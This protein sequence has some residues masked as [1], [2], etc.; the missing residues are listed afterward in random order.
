[1][2]NKNDK[3]IYWVL[4]I[5][6][7]IVLLYMGKQGMFQSQFAL[8]QDTINQLDTAKEQPGT[9]CSIT[10]SR[11]IINAGDTVTGTINDG[12]NTQCGIYYRIDSG[13]W[14]FGGIVTT[15]SNGRYTETR[16]PDIAGT[17]DFAAICGT[18]ITN[19]ATLVVNPVSTTTTT[20][21]PTTTTI[22]VWNVGDIVS[23]ESGSGAMPE[24]GGV[25]FE[26]HDLINFEVVPGGLRRLGARI[27]TNWDYVNQD[28]CYGMVYQEGMEWMFTDSDSVEWHVV[29]NVPQAHS[30]DLCPLDW[31][32]TNLW[33][34][35]FWKTQNIIGCE[36]N[37]DWTV[38]IY[39]CE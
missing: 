26:F 5:A 29:D 32:G 18:C 36:I 16:T 31:D 4:G 7:L 21:P 33:F 20:I 38:E 12:K 39:V 9:D 37:Y 30:E 22:P 6:F 2:A 25:G 10:F 28:M 8:N 19:Q 11:S 1:M 34:L 27:Y 17:Y 35:D 15:D 24:S 14:L 23:S 3:T 13:A